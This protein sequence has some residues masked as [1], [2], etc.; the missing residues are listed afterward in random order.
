MDITTIEMLLLHY[1]SGNLGPAEGLVAAAHVSLNREARRKLAEFEALGGQ[2]MLDHTPVAVTEQ[3]LSAVLSKINSAPANADYSDADDK[4]DTLLADVPCAIKKLLLGHCATR[5]GWR[6]IA[7]G[8]SEIMLRIDSPNPCRHQLRLI[9]LE[10]GAQ[11]RLTHR[12]RIMMLIMAGQTVAAGKLFHTGDMI[13][14]EAQSTFPARIDMTAGQD[15][16]TVLALTYPAAP[17]WRR[18]F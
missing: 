1:A 17:W 5:R 6:P 14:A 12:A 2:V 16:C 8:Q 13:M 10:Q 4:Q 7:A 15:G 9:R 3:C 11:M 18:M